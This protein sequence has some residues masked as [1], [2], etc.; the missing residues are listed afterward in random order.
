[1]VS[2]H[3]FPQS[4][5]S[6]VLFPENMTDER[7][8]QLRNH[9]ATIWVL[10]DHLE[11]NPQASWKIDK[12]L[13]EGNNRLK[14]GGTEASQRGSRRMN[15]C[16][17]TTWTFWEGREILAQNS[18]EYPSIFFRK[19]LQLLFFNASASELSD[20]GANQCGL[21]ASELGSLRHD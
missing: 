8:R 1:M 5:L 12:E 9:E 3:W 20:I 10:R 19:A 18:S 16:R 13:W 2:D 11:R 4:S 6:G 21:L 7:H 17:E 14:S 15:G